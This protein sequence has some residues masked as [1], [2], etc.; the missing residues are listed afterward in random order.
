MSYYH[1]AVYEYWVSKWGA[2][3]DYY[4]CTEEGTNHAVTVVGW[5]DNVPHPSPWHLGTGAWII[6]NSWGTGWGNAGYFYLAYNSS[7]AK[8]IIQLGYKD[9]VPGEELLYWDEAGF[10]NS[11]G[12]GYTNAW[13]ANVFTAAQSGNLTHVDFWTTSINAQYEIYVWNGYFGVVLAHQ[14]GNCQELGY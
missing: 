3:Y 12:Y 14:T 11:K 5:D 2:I 7:C 13:M 4:P 9:P 6:K 1:D 10:V 8:R